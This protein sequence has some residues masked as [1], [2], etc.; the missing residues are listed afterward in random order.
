VQRLA[1][2]TDLT[3]PALLRKQVLSLVIF[4]RDG[5]LIEDTGYPIDPATLI[6]KQG[7]LRMLSWLRSQG[8]I[9]AV[10]TNQSGVARGYFSLDQVH[11]FHAA[12]NAQI[13]A[14]GGRIDAY[15]ICPHLPNGAVTRYA[16]DCECRK[17]KPGLIQQLLA[18]FQVAPQNAVMIGD[19]DR[20]IE[21]GRAAG[22]VSFLYRG[23]D[24]FEFTKAVISSHFGLELITAKEPLTSQYEVKVKL[25]NN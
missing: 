15:A 13:K 19:R 21:A 2:A 17:P 10:A 23:G 7:A 16:L 1:A 22:V 12:M 25:I 3:Q 11:A 4:D 6:W 14:R 8:T 5:T 9:V 20:D 18:L 24:L